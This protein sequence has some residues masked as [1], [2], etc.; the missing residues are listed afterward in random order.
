MLSLTKADT[1]KQPRPIGE[2]EQELEKRL[3]QKE[4]T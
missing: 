1:L 4:L 3:D 2:G